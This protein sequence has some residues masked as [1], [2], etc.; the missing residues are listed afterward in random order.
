MHE[1]KITLLTMDCCQKN[2]MEKESKKI[3]GAV[4]QIFKDVTGQHGLELI[5]IPNKYDSNTTKVDIRLILFFKNQV[6]SQ[7]KGIEHVC[8]H[9]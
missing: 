7:V 6:Q 3:K 5:K 9:H 1:V 8:T 4:L 2:R